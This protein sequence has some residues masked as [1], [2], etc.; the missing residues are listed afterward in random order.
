MKE[1]IKSLTPVYGTHRMLMEYSDKMYLPGIRRNVS[2]RESNYNLIRTLA[3]WK[4]H[5]EKAWP[6]VTIMANED[7]HGLSE[8][9]AKSGEEI[10]LNATVQ[11]GM[12]TPEDVTVEVYYGPVRN[13]G[14]IQGQSIPTQ[15]MHQTD[16]ST[17]FYEAK[18]SLS[19]GGEYGYS[20][21]VIPN[22]PS[23][24]NKFDLPLIK[25]VS[26]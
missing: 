10:T 4:Q 26:A 24:M 8:R 12:L 23:Q 15:V 2:S 18:I 25:W 17:F 6:Q 3:N 19:D 22:H 9:D 14:I 20:F 11:L 5:V 13:N 1:S 21:R 16:A 7:I